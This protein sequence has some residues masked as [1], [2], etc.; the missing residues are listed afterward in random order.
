ML[1]DWRCVPM[2]R[3]FGIPRAASSTRATAPEAFPS[4]RAARNAAAGID[5]TG[6]RAIYM[7]NGLIVEPRRTGRRSAG[8]SMQATPRFGVAYDFRNT[9][10]D[11]QTDVELYQRALER[12]HYAEEL[13]FDQFWLSEH[14]FVP[15][16]HSPAPLTIAAAIAARTESIRI[17]TC[18]Y[19][20]PLHHPLQVAEEV[21]TLDILSSGRMDLGV[22]LG[23]RREEFAAFGVDRRERASRM[24][25]SCEILVRAW[26]EDGWAFD[27]R[28]FSLE[29]VSV[30]P[31]PVQKPHPPLWLSARNEKAARRAARLRCP[32]MIAPAPFN[33]GAGAVYRAYATELRELD[34]D[35]RE[36][37]V[38]GTF[39]VRVLA[40]DEPHPQKPRERTS[41]AHNERMRQYVQW[42]G[43]AA[44]VPGDAAR[45][46]DPPQELAEE[47]GV[48][49]DAKTCISAIERLVAEVPFTHLSVGTTSI[50]AM[51]RFTREVMPHFRS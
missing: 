47:I 6:R 5:W 50:T 38:A 26:T 14:H 24:D 29:D 51:E 32:L 39:G 3:P 30:H 42:Y 7:I 22:G 37:P 48:V 9:R 28:H 4:L 2:W 21:A 16:G 46:S 19:L 44:D 41:A 15:E 23:Y 34:E 1:R 27:G 11:E 36:Y 18:V 49:G 33:I 25:E 13:G 8:G 43:D 10:P 17:G 35:P 20:L 31:K 12:I 45:I 40:D